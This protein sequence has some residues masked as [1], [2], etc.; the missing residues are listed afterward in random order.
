[1]TMTKDHLWI[2]SRQM[3]QI[4]KWQFIKIKGKAPYPMRCLSL[5]GRDNYVSQRELL[6][7][8]F[9][10]FDSQ[11]LVVSLRRRKKSHKE[12]RPW[13]LALGM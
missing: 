6:I 13:W 11:T 7:A 4:G 10:F 3:W 12:N 9:P 2:E 5:V 1:M 8:E